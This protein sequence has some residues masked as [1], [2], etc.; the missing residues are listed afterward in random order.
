MYKNKYIEKEY[1][2]D[3]IFDRLNW[4]QIIIRIED[5]IAVIWSKYNGA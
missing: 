3:T 5:I 4:I 2:H 1:K